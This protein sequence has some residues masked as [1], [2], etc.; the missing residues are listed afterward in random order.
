V[1]SSTSL[2]QDVLSIFSDSSMLF[3]KHSFIYILFLD[4]KFCLF[5]KLFGL[6]NY[7][8]CLQLWFLLN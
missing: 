2:H 1:L 8:F 7:V 3:S 6:S 5:L 4:I